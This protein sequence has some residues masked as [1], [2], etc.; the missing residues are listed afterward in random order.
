MKPYIIKSVINKDGTSRYRYSPEKI[1]RVVSTKTAKTLTDLLC[2][3]VERGTG[4]SA[5]IKG[6]RIAGKTGTTQQLVDGEYSKTNYTASFAGYFPAYNPKAA[7]IVVLDKPRGTYY[8]GSTAAPIFKSIAT[9]L[10][11]SNPAFLRTGAGEQDIAKQDSVSV[12]SICGLT[13]DDATEIL[14][15]AG[16]KLDKPDI[17]SIIIKQ[18][19]APGLFIEKGSIIRIETIDDHAD[20]KNFKPD[21][22]GLPL[23]RALTILNKTGC[24][25]K[26]SGSGNV[27]KQSWSKDAKG[28]N[29]CVIEC[30]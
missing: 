12:P 23:R 24:K 22:T 4:V 19:P 26:V 3:V 14:I 15:S 10:I 28:N 16:L 7:I 20:P 27:K 11:S 2:G 18:S 5:K 29:I 21:V 25:I 17:K 30:G 13:V 8:G 1:R 9:R 6:I